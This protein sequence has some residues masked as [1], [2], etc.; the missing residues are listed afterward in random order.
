MAFFDIP[1]HW[2][3]EQALAVYEFL[4]QL[5][6]RIWEYYEVR[7]VETLRREIAGDRHDKPVD[8]SDFNDDLPF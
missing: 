4:A 8:S 1:E 5:Q 3:N 7:L 2:S 6:D